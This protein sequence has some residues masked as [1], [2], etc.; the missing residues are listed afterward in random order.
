MTHKSVN[1]ISYHLSSL[2]ISNDMLIDDDFLDEKFVSTT[3]ITR[4][5]LYFDDVAN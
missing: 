4:W 1:G 5:Q 2:P 3:S